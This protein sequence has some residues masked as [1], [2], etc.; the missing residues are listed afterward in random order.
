MVPL[1]LPVV[2][3]LLIIVLSAPIVIPNM[4]P[5]AT[6]MCMLRPPLLWKLVDMF[7]GPQSRRPQVLLVRRRADRTL[8]L[9]L[10]PSIMVFVLLLNSM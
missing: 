7:I 3:A 6:T 9:E 10:G 1:S 4:L 2:S 8:A 5:L